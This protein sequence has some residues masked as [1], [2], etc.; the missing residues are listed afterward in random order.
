[1]TYDLILRSGHIIDP[2]QGIDGVFDIAFAGGRVA[3]I[4]SSINDDAFQ[5]KDV[6]GLYV[7]PGLIDLHT[8]VY[9]GGTFLGVDATML[10][11]RSGMTT[12]IDAGSAGAA[13]IRG[14]LEQCAPMT[15]TRILAFINLAVTGIFVDE[16]RI[17][18][19]EA[20]DL[21]LL[22]VKHCVDAAKRHQ[23]AVV[24]VKIRVGASTTKHLGAMPLHMAIRAGE[25]ANLPVMV[26]IGAGMP[27]RIEDIVEPL[28]KGDILTH[29]CTPKMN[30][31]MTREGFLRDCMIAARERGVIMDVGH[32]A[33]SFG[34]GVAARMLELGFAPDV[35][36]SDVH[37]GC[38]DGPAQDVLAI[39]SKFLALGLPLVDIVRAATATPAA[40]C[41]RPELGSLVPQS[42][43]DAAVIEI[44]QERTVFRDSVGETLTGDRR[45]VA[46]G[47]VIGGRWWRDAELRRDPA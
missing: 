23:D 40:V 39:M 34:F 32:G 37:A 10:A 29:F 15:P 33:G 14:L 6:S 22:D 42:I 44:K 31:P 19:G 20:E 11:A 21:R 13:N 46:R 7:F 45:F 43:G 26:H 36:S 4:G 24:G 41:R 35:I 2:S 27:P 25:L 17:S 12:A 30:S 1:M 38:V 16:G 9:W 18:M 5:V 8:H 28:R 3:A 47:V